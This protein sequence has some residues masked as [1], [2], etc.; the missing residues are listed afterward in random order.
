MTQM[1]GKNTNNTL[2]DMNENDIV[3][4]EWIHVDSIV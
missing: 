3:E 4:W 1:L 2:T